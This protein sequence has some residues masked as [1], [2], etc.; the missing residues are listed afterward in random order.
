MFCVGR[1]SACR[2]SASRTRRLDHADD[3]LGH[4]ILQREDIVQGVLEPVGPNL[5]ALADVDELHADPHA[6]AGLADASFQHIANAELA[7]RFGRAD[8]FALERQDWT[9]A[10]TKMERTRDSDWTI[11][12]TMPSAK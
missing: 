3:A 7:R 4:A 9:L 12:T 1:G 6:A 11:S 8:P 2:T 10:M 5:G